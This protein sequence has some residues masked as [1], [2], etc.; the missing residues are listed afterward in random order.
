MLHWISWELVTLGDE[1]LIKNSIFGIKWIYF[2]EKIKWEFY[3]V[4]FL[5]ANHNTFFYAI[6]DDILQIQIFNKLIKISGIWV[7]TANYIVTKFSLS[8]IQQAIS[9]ANLDFF[10][11]VPGV[12]AKT[13]KKIILELKDKISI[14][15]I[16][17]LDQHNQVKAKIIKTLTNLGYPKNKV[18]ELL[19]DIKNF[20]NP[21]EVIQQ[22]VKQL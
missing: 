20:D 2:W 16:E 3:L 12:W 18:I 13:A 14:E 9:E 5:D 19:K 22:I 11:Q 7:K 6:F 4:P 1:V 21:S 8:E 17:K 10:T 15:D